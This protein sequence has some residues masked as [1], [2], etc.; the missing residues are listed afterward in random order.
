MTRDTLNAAVRDSLYMNRSVV[1]VMLAYILFAVILGRLGGFEVALHVYSEVTALLIFFSL[2]MVLIPVVLF[3]LYRHRP[4]SPIRFSWRLLSK[5]LRIVE[6]GLVALPCILL[7]T[8]FSSAFTSIKSAI[9]H[10]HPYRLD[11][12]FAHW[13]SLIHGGHAWELIHPLV[14]FP[15]VTFAINFSY[16][17]WLFVMSIS[18]AAATVMLGNRRLR[19]QYLLTFLGCWILIG[20]LAAI[21]LSSVGPCFYGL[22]Y[23]DDPYA[24][25]MSYLR[26]VDEV[27]PIWALPTQDMLWERHIASS[28]GL[29]SGI[30]AMPS[31]HVAI[32]TLNALFLSK[33]S[34]KAGLLGWAYLAVI[35]LGSVH[36]GWHYAIDG[37]A[38]IIGVLVIWRVA[39][40]WAALGPAPAPVARAS[41]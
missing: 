15:I 24:P 20:S 2:C 18:F 41:A 26:S 33:L 6:R 16:N 12:L 32:T 5:D 30:S 10:L 39:G 7:F 9:G 40:W 36:L 3:Q 19:E 38:S 14:G 25:L 34:R 17:F 31:V 4:V 1:V 8:L 28:T 37:Y 22:L 21:G 11:P 35:L 23:P 29:G 13:D 27:Y